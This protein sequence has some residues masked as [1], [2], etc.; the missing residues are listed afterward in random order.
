MERVAFRA[1]SH[2]W[3]LVT[4]TLD[5]KLFDESPIEGLSFVKRNRAVSRTVNRW[6]REKGLDPH[7]AWFAKMELQKSGMPH[8]HVLCEIPMERVDVETGEVL[9]VVLRRPTAEDI[10]DFFGRYGDGSAPVGLWKWGRSDV[11]QGAEASPLVA[12]QYMTKY[13]CKEGGGDGCSTLERA[14]LPATGVHWVHASRG[15]WAI[16]GLSDPVEDDEELGPMKDDEVTG[17][18]KPI[19]TLAERVETCKRCSVL[20]IE[21]PGAGYSVDSPMLPCSR[22]VLANGLA[23][24]GI[25]VEEFERRPDSKSEASLVK[26]IALDVAALRVVAGSFASS[27]FDEFVAEV[28]EVVRFEDFGGDRSVRGAEEWRAGKESLRAAEA[29]RP[30]EP[31]SSRDAFW[32]EHLPPGEELPR[33]DAADE[34]AESRVPPALRNRHQVP[35]PRSKG[36]HLPKKRRGGDD[37]VR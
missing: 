20:R 32:R 33:A 8:W 25:V 28:E 3:I 35:V 23:S 30:A 13:A 26:T 29:L 34:R 11:Q 37:A 31:W 2:V 21:I 4:F 22:S 6:Y 36:P 24:M 16:A 17:H 1:D 7:G 9:P 18:E 27:R 19:A 14:G 10:G 15:F 12:V 5:P